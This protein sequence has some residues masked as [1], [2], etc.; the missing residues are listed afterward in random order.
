MIIYALFSSPGTDVHGEVL[1]YPRRRPRRRR[2][3]R[4]RRRGHPKLKFFCRLII[5]AF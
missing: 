1:R 5:S 2:R 3:R 4:R